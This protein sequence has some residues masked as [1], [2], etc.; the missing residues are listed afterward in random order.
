MP[1]RVSSFW[2]T[3][4]PFLSLLS[5][6]QGFCST[7]CQPVH[8][9]TLLSMIYPHKALSATAQRTSQTSEHDGDS[10]VA[11]ARLL[12]CRIGGCVARRQLD[13]IT[14]CC[15]CRCLKVYSLTSLLSAPC[16][17]VLTYSFAIFFL[18]SVLVGKNGKKPAL[19][20]LCCL[21]A[22]FGML[23]CPSGM[24]RKLESFGDPNFGIDS[25]ALFPKTSEFSKTFWK[26]SRS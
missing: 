16:F 20:L 17:Y 23:C 14:C 15:C 1:P 7:F 12:Q 13:L 18:T 10:L 4:S 8:L 3:Y 2:R 21:C 25:C 26:W 19:P 6:Q 11:S 9:Q 5:A 24:M 22:K